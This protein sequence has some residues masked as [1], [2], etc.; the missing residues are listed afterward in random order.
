MPQSRY[1]GRLAPSPTGALHLGTAR[2]ALLAWLAARSEHGA[3]VLR[4][5]DLDGPRVVPG[6]A[7]AIAADLRWLG[8]DWDEGPDQGGEFG[9][10]RQ[11]DRSEHYE[12]ALAVLERAGLLF[13]CS[14]SRAE[15][16]A[17]SAPHGD[18]GPRYPGTCRE[19]PRQPERA[20]SLR[21][22]MPAGEAFVDR[23]YADQA[24]SVADDF[25]VRRS[26]GLYAYQLAVVA[27]DIAMQVTEVVRGADLL[28]S[29]PRQI[30]L[31]RALGANPP[32]FFHVPLVIG[33]DGNR[34]AKRHG[35]PAL[36]DYRKQGVAPERLVGALAA[37]VGLAKPGE[38]L[39][40]S[41]LIPRF[42]ARRLP[43]VSTSFAGLLPS[44]GTGVWK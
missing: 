6:A 38:E 31:H 13:R 8:L 34:L 17:S 14:C 1:R 37:S 44:G 33:S 12:R 42:E 15:I 24:S 25:V 19:G 22:R 7:E 26:D 40:P 39:R 3:V 5:E 4:I 41:D 43:T 28:E 35:S 18:L 9:P 30:A 10:Y 21:F 2:T 36:A 32:R 23:L 11:S 27:D 16:N 20:C 29:T